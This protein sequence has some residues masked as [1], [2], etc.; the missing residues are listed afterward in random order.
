MSTFNFA[1]FRSQFPEFADESKYPDPLLQMY[2]DMAQTFISTSGSPC[3]GFSAGQLALALNQMTAHLLILG[4]Q[5]ASN[6]ESNQGG[7]ETSA[8]IGEISV[9]KLAPPVSGA[10][11]FWLYQTPYG[12]ALMALLSAISVGGFSVGGLDERSSFRKAGGVFF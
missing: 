9:A 1:L 10:W 7:F 4:A 6:P 8:S 2:F 11:D 12:Q 5:A 3:S